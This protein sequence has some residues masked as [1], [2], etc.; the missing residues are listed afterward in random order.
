MLRPQY[1][2][3]WVFYP[4]FGLLLAGVVWLFYNFQLQ[5]FQ[6]HQLTGQG[7]QGAIWG[8]IVANIVHF[9][10]I[11]H[12]GIAISAS[13]RILNLERYKQLARI[14]ELVT[15]A[16]LTTAVLNISMDVGRPDRF[17]FNVIKHGRF[18]APFVWSMTV[19]SAYYIGSTV[20]LYLAMRRDLYICSQVLPPHK[21]WFYK[22][23]ALGYSD[24]PQSRQTHHRVVW[25]IAVIILPIMVSVHSVYGY[26]FGM[27]AGRPGWFN[28]FQAPYFV[29]GAIVT[30]FSFVILVLG[31]LRKAFKWEQVFYPRIFKGLGVF[32]GFVTWLYLYFLFSEWLTGTYAPPS[33]ERE[34]FHDILFG[35]FAKITWPGTI[36]GMVI[37]FWV[38]FIQGANPRICSIN[39]TLAAALPVF[40]SMW[41]WRY[42]IVVP[43]FYHPHL[44]YKIAPYTPTFFDW[45]LIIGSLIFCVFLF[46]ILVKILPV[47]ELPEDLEVSTESVLIPAYYRSPYEKIKNFLAI[48]KNISIPLTLIAGIGFIAYGIITRE[49]P[50]AP[51]IWVL[52]ICIL[53]TLPLQICVLPWRE[54][55]R[56]Y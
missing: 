23:L 30:G 31:V 53:W 7:S 20:Y 50:P 41:I 37:P 39:L 15:L 32:L 3:S 48:L 55:A 18:H 28:P 6:G 1:N 45:S 26:I 11:S 24:T 17:L 42:L 29:L 38:F 21:R 4:Y 19:I 36:L 56:G 33:A 5:F 10:G 12:V 22:L 25:W 43:S 14:A 34:V 47:L 52:G 40:I 9:I 49:N 44:P 35:R 13:V 16:S 51:A 2:T 8:I 46:T 54:W 27:Q